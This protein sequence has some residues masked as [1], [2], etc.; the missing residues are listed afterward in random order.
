[1]VMKTSCLKN[2]VL[3]FSDIEKTGIV[4][5]LVLIYFVI[6]MP[7][8]YSQYPGGNNLFINSHADSVYAA[9]QSAERLKSVTDPESAGKKKD[10]KIELNSSD[11][12][13][14]KRVYGIGSWYSRKIVRYRERL[15]GFYCV[16]QLRE[17]KMREGTYERISPQLYVDTSYI[18]KINLD[19]IGFKN[20]L[21]HPYFDYDM[22][23]GV[24]KLRKEDSNITS[25]DLLEKNI[26]S[27]SQY[28][29]IRRYC[30]E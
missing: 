26:V 25:K 15:G 19:T 2:N 23:K 9:S 16:S 13:E 27:R 12:T 7:D 24:F 6:I 8:L 1:M 18:R 30:I 29:K 5:V 4:I 28:Q 11:T 17:I 21:S 20:L 14:L 3:K 10:V 22:V